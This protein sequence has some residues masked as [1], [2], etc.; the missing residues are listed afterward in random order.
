MLIVSTEQRTIAAARAAKLG[1]PCHH[2]V[3]DKGAFLRDHTAHAGIAL[4]NV[5]YVGNDVNDLPALEIVGLPV[6]VRDAHPDA[7]RVA[8]LIL[9]QEGGHGAVRELCDRLLTHLALEA[10]RTS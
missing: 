3:R 10:Q 7:R 9:E 5:I 1:I 2:G 6:V 8:R 4:E